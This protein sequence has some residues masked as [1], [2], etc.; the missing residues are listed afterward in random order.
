MPL[1]RSLKACLEI[2][3]LSKN[4]R[5]NVRNERHATS[6]EKLLHFE[7]MVAEDGFEPPTQGL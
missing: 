3:I 1:K 2:L 4:Q 5:Q 6:G 7:V